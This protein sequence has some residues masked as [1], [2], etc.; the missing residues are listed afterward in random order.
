[1]K[2]IKTKDKYEIF[3][4]SLRKSR[5]VGCDEGCI[6]WALVAASVFA[7]DILFF[8][9]FNFVLACVYPRDNMSLVVGT[10]HKNHVSTL[11][12]NLT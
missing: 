8:F 7:A 2:L 11:I 4:F 6:G 12:E 10:S 3:L 1:M 9:F 5:G